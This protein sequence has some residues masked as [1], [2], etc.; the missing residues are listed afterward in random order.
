MTQTQDFKPGTLDAQDVLRLA[1]TSKVYGAAV[2]TPLSAAPG[3]SARTGNA[4][5]LKREDQQP[6]FS[7]KL[8][9]AYNK[10]SQLTPEE[11][12]RGVICASAGNHAQGVAYAA[13]QLVLRA[14]IVMPAT[15]PEIKVQACRQRG[16]E[17]VLYGDSFSDAETHAYALQQGGGLTFVHPYDDP[18]V[19]AGQGTVALE[20]LR[21]VEAP[22]GYT[23]FVP[24]G[25][26]GLIAGVAGVLKALRPDV[27][28]VGVEPDD[29]DAMYR[30]L[31]AGERV[32]LDQVG[33]FVDGVAVKQ[34]GAYTFD[35][36]RRYVD[37]WVR[38]T[39]DEVCA[40]IKDV[41][42]DTR[43]V[44]EPAGA[45]AVAG[46][47]QYAQ[48]RGL[49]GETLVA[50]TGGANVNF[51]RLRHV[52]ER[53]EIG[54]RREAILAVTIPERPGAFRQFIEVIGP[55]AITEFNYR[56]APRADARIFV[57][58]QL[59]HPAERAELAGALTARGYAVTDLTDDELAKVHVRHMVGGRAPEAVDERVYSFT[60]PE[61]PGAL[62][63]FLTH[64]H[65]RWNISLFHYRN[66]GS[67][68]GRVLAG[69]Q[70]PDA[71]LGDFAAFLGELGYP[72]EDMT[73]NAAYRLFLT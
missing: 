44:M 50:L 60:F 29:S 13:Q 5:W 19:L 11:A 57:G 7:F 71:D 46:L 63:E 62:L 59:T 31:Q 68:H 43:A 4:V 24:V 22:Q 3:L 37:D 52:A 61:R 27:R 67:A 33:I 34:V 26:G 10:M 65:A 38:V 49:K 72:A 58:V 20:L 14:V 1:L 39:T 18:L 40:A 48:E 8:R 21:Q 36:T 41:F 16:A 70:V 42:D 12:A 45:L 17:V 51:D 2:E 69:I 64:L 25:G 73:G 32:R 28:I 30:S 23:L 15:T 66:H 53:A 9:G 55:R 35:L 47:K 6:I 56:Y 54:E